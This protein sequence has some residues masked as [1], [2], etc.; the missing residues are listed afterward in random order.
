[1]GS[2]QV[3]DVRIKNTNIIFDSFWQFI[4][5]GLVSS[6]FTAYVHS[7]RVGVM[8][9]CGTTVELFTMLWVYEV[10]CHAQLWCTYNGF[11]SFRCLQANKGIYDSYRRCCMTNP[12]GYT[13]CYAVVAQGPGSWALVNCVCALVESYFFCC[14][15]NKKLQYE[16]SSRVLS[17]KQGWCI[18]ENLPKVPGDWCLLVTLV[19]ILKSSPGDTQHFVE[20]LIFL[21]PQ[22][23]LYNAMSVLF[24]IQMSAWRKWVY[25]RLDT[26]LGNLRLY[27]C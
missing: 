12:V 20:S 8:L 7:F 25:H 19:M 1:V 11:S 22:I 6:Y 5:N 26:S 10:C 18:H 13:H 9:A 4:L 15:C 23:Y 3:L 17:C 2:N 16:R 24:F 27:C 21:W 14:L